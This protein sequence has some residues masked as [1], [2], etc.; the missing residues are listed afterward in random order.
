MTFKSSVTFPGARQ[1]DFQTTCSH[2]KHMPLH[3]LLSVE[4]NI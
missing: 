1:E 2:F 3:W 4:Q